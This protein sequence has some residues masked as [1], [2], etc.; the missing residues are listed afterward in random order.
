MT[1]DQIRNPSLLLF[2]KHHL[3]GPLAVK[4]GVLKRPYIVVSLRGGFPLALVDDLSDTRHFT[5]HRSRQEADLMSRIGAEHRGDGAELGGEIRVNK[6]NA[7]SV[8]TSVD[9]R[10]KRLVV[11]LSLS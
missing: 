7:H 8:G 6:E 10:R 2:S 1:E 5:M 9:C 3:V 11:E 4:N